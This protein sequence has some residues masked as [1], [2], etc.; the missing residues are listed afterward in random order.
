MRRGS[1][2]CLVLLRFCY[3]YGFVSF[4]QHIMSSLKVRMAESPSSA[5]RW[6]GPRIGHGFDIHQLSEE[7]RRPLVVA[8]V[9][10]QHS[11]GTVAHSDGDTVFHRYAM[12]LACM[13]W[14]ERNAFVNS[15]LWMQ[16]LVRLVSQT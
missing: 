14:L 7:A 9:T 13:T 6:F 1:V 16:F 2:L 15:V 12:H 3:I 8:G 11:R 5:D 10:L 4:V